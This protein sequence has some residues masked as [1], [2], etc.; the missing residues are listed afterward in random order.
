MSES[1]QITNPA[2]IAAVKAGELE[3]E[4]YSDGEVFADAVALCNWRYGVI[5][6]S[7]VESTVP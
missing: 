6:G 5:Q 3:G 1:I 7:G 2:E 4:I